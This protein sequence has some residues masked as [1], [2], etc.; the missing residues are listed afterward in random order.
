MEWQVICRGVRVPLTHSM[1]R[2]RRQ[3]VLHKRDFDKHFLD[4]GYLESEVGFYI[5]CGGRNPPNEH[6]RDNCYVFSFFHLDE[7]IISHHDHT[8]EASP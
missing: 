2:S 4:T 8:R 7:G 6:S 1:N 5:N 3:M